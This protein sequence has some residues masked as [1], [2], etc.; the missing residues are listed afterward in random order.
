MLIIGKHELEI[1][2]K[3]INEIYYDSEYELPFGSYVSKKISLDEILQES[4]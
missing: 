1:E 4:K 2:K 3:V